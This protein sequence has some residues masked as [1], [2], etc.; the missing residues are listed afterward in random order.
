[1]LEVLQYWFSRRQTQ[2]QE[3]IVLSNMLW[4]T[5]KISMQ[6]WCWWLWF[7][8]ISPSYALWMCLLGAGW[9]VVFADVAELLWSPISRGRKSYRAIAIRLLVVVQCIGY[10]VLSMQWGG[11]CPYPCKT[12]TSIA[13]MQCITSRAKSTLQPGWPGQLASFVF[14]FSHFRICYETLRAKWAKWVGKLTRVDHQQCRDKG[15]DLL[16]LPAII[17]GCCAQTL[18]RRPLQ[19]TKTKSKTCWALRR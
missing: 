6:G 1:M 2:T 16:A 9:L 5:C 12:P 15:G 19:K 13:S 18:A 11:L 7:E 3:Q 4:K 8:A 10:W 14:L 17:L